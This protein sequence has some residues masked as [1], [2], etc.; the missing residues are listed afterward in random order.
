MI[1]VVP[2]THL[3]HENIKKYCNRLDNF[4]KMIEKNWNE[5]I[6]DKYTVVHLSDISF[7]EEWV[8]RLGGLVN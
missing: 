7:Q 2:D 6:T 5:T 3:A 4:E 1:Y 8:K